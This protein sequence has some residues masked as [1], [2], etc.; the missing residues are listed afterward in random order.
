MRIKDLSYKDSEIGWE[1]PHINFESLTLL[2]GASGVG[3]TRIL[4]ALIELHRLARGKKMPLTRWRIGFEAENIEYIWSG[5]FGPQYI[6]NERIIANSQVI[7]ER[8]GDDIQF[9]GKAT[10]RLPREQSLAFSLRAEPLAAPIHKALQRIIFKDYKINEA[11]LLEDFR[12]VNLAEIKNL[13]DIQSSD[14]QLFTKLY[15]AQ[16]NAPD[17]FAQIKSRFI[18]I[19]PT[20]ENIE[21]HSSPL[22]ELRIKEYGLDRWIR[23]RDVSNGMLRS[24]LQIS[25]LYL[26]EEGS[27][28][29]LDEFEHGLGANCIDEI[30]D[31][32][33]RN[34]RKL[35]FILS[36]HHPYIINNISFANW[37]LISRHC[38]QIRAQDAAE[39]E[40]GRSRH[41]AFMQL[42]QLEAYQNGCDV[43]S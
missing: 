22:P 38:G 31:E 25:D 32:V 30:T 40:L 7:A 15:L 33:L 1:L 3:K 28:F 8:N 35:Q 13:T 12:N 18:D 11:A 29:L 41:S 26:C 37:R 2:V 17:T 43:Q 42:M 36:S 14:L 6:E 5:E 39:L 16:N 27:V 23:Q 34:T 21:I 9:L 19:F 10:I 4:R 24:L 20:I